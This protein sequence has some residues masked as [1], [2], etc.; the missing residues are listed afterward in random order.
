LLGYMAAKWNMPAACRG[1]ASSWQC[2]S[3]CSQ[4]KQGVAGSDMAAGRGPAKAKAA[5]VAGEC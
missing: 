2:L 4:L 3:S 1:T 5:E